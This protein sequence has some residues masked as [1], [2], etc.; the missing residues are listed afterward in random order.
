MCTDGLW[1]HVPTTRE[2]AAA[3]AELAGRPAIAV[4]RAL[5]DRALA[6]GGHDNITVAVIDIEP[7]GPRPAAEGSRHELHR[8]DVPERAPA[9]R[10]DRR[11]RHRDRD[12]DRRA[13]AGVD[14][15]PVA[16]TT[17]VV[18]VLD[19]SGSMTPVRKIAPLKRAA[20]AAIAELRDGVLFAIVA[21]THEAD[22][23]PVGDAPLVVASDA[24]RRAA[25][26]AVDGARAPAVARPSAAG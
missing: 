13:A 21:G 17:A 26:A 5:T 9:G 8:R 7:T 20:A 1:N 11:R 3:V 4:A 10:R 19:V 25:T 18:L 22:V 6:A 24:T 16:T 23:V 15:P 2:L 14:A 12:R